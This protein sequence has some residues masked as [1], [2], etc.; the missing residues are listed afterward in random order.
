MNK[1]RIAA[2]FKILQCFNLAAICA[3][4]VWHAYAFY[5]QQAI[6]YE[7]RP[8][9]MEWQPLPGHQQNTS[10]IMT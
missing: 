2:G 6:T 1:T 10:R 9:V 3:L 7:A 8:H 4:S 5:L